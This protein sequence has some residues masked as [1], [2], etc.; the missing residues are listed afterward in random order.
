MLEI[1][2]SRT[3][4]S[5]IRYE[6][7]DRDTGELL[8]PPDPNT[9]PLQQRQTANLAAAAA[10]TGGV[11]ARNNDPSSPSET[12]MRL[13]EYY[14]GINVPRVD[15]DFYSPGRV[16]NVILRDVVENPARPLLAPTIFGEAFYYQQ[17]RQQEHPPHQ[18]GPLRQ[19]EEQ[20][21]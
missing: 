14:Y 8:R 15:S 4:I 2:R 13:A 6:F 19:Q 5:V 10:A 3:D 20:H 21:Y 12:T 9:E 16:R 18:Q 11:A 7:H 1:P 17:R